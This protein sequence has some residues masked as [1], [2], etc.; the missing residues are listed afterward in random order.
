MH[1]N[2]YSASLN[3]ALFSDVKHLTVSSPSHINIT[4]N[5][6]TKFPLNTFLAGNGTSN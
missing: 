3:T 2:K 1:S 6:T 5:Y 4:E